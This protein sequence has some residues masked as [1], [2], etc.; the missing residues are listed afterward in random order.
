MGFGF[1]SVV[2]YA[3]NEALFFDLPTFCGFS[4]SNMQGYV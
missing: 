4:I 3:K 2:D 1:W